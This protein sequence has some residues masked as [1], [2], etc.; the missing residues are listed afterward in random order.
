M[1][2]PYE[3]VAIRYGTL[4]NRKSEF[5]YRFGSYGEPDSEVEMGY[6]FWLL[7]RPGSTVLVD[8]GFDPTVGARRGRTCVVAPLEAL[9]RLGVQPE[10]VDAVVVT[11]C[12]YDH[13]GNLHAFPHAELVLP[14]KEL[15]FWTSPLAEREQFAS[16]VEPDDVALL[17]QAV[18]EGRARLTDGREEI[19]EGV[20]AIQV[21]GHSPGQQLTTVAAAGGVVVLASDA[22]HFYEELE[23]D[24]PFGIVA[25]L[26]RMYATY[27][28]LRE[29]AASGATVIPGHDSEVLRR[30]PAVDGSNGNAVRVG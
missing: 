13:T 18:G 6:F 22:F 30:F 8:T 1:G 24:R 4:R 10:Q 26:A 11:H 21:G 17:V 19:L 28:L 25:D 20:T 16:H 27:D 5:F 2:E 7:R 3:V 9:R 15:E 14:Q 29:L 12:H 23:L